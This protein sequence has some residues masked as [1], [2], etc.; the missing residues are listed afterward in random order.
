MRRKTTLKRWTLTDTAVIYHELEF[1]FFK[2][3]HI[4]TLSLYQSLGIIGSK[5]LKIVSLSA[6]V[7]SLPKY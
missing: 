7:R 5:I 1:K 4:K 3:I 2:Y 6:Y